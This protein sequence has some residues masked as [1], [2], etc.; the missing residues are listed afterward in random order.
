MISSIAIDDEPIAL[1]II[2][3]HASKLS[4][5]SLKATF[6]SPVK[7]MEYLQQE[8]VDLIFLDINM[9]D[10]SGIEL[11]KIINKRFGIIFTTAHA[12]YAIQ[13][14]ELAAIDYLLKPISLDRFLSACMRAQE[15]LSTSSSEKE[16]AVF[17]KDG[18]E[19]VKVNLADLLYIEA[20]DNYVIFHETKRKT[21]TRMTLAEAEEKLPADI[22]MRVHKSFLVNFAHIEKI[23][24]EQVIVNSK[25]IPVS[26]SYRKELLRKIQ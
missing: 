20:S 13:A 3:S 24:S 22:F 8:P 16:K 11:S 1:D 18:Y 19:W 12:D 25:A 7:A 10:I 14:F 9:P 2:R 15:Q 17:I 21:T 6:F 4:F 23:H 26:A 5:L